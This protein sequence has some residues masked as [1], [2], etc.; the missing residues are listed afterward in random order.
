MN[1]GRLFR[2]GRWFWSLFVAVLVVVNLLPVGWMVLGSLQENGDL[3]EGRVGLSRGS[4]EVMELLPL[5]DGVLA[6]TAGG[7]LHLVRAESQ[8]L[9]VRFSRELG[10]WGN[11]LAVENENLWVLSGTQGLERMEASSFAVGEH[12]DIDDFRMAYLAR[13]P[14][15]KWL[16]LDRTAVETSELLALP[17]VVLATFRTTGFPGVVQVDRRSHALKFLVFGQELPFPVDQFVDL[18]KGR[19]AMVGDR[20]IVLWSVAGAKVIDQFQWGRDLP[21]ERANLVAALDDSLLLCRRDQAWVYS[22][23]GRQVVKALDTSC[24]LKGGRIL[25]VAVDERRYWFGTASGVWGIDRRAGAP[26]GEDSLPLAPVDHPAGA[27]WMANG[28]I[29]MALAGGRFWAAGSH[30]EIAQGKLAGNLEL[31]RSGQLPPGRLRLWTENYAALWERLEFGKCLRNS[32]L[33]SLLVTVITVCLAVFS[34][35]ALGR[36]SFPGKEGFGLTALAT[37]AVPGIAFLIPLYLGFLRLQKITEGT[38]PFG[39]DGLRLVGS[40]W[41]VVLIYSVFFVPFSIWILRGFFRALPR[42]LEAAAKL[43]G[44]SSWGA[45]WKVALPAVRPGILVTGLYVFVSVWD[46]LLFAWVLTAERAFTVPVGIRTFSGN[47][48]TRSDLLLASGALAT[49]PV[50]MLFFLLQGRIIAGLVPRTSRK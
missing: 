38:E 46:E 27:P 17:E 50:L 1:L 4:N 43:D 7:Q 14:T 6:A 3:Q 28:V 9:V 44:L 25:S 16:G 11:A 29:K 10:S 48:Q 33:V 49:L 40:L 22:L 31:E 35:Y 45:F 21:P 23:P 26:L 32:L 42:N 2:S 18:G 37:Q 8:G 24:G 20:G 30:G 41:G 12:W 39:P 13:I 19:V 47:F 36:L 5:R 15:G 34:A